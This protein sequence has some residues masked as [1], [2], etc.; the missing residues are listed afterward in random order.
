MRVGGCGVRRRFERGGVEGRCGNRGRGGGDRRRDLDRFVIDDAHD[1]TRDAHVVLEE[2]DRG[3]LAD[4]AREQRLGRDLARPGNVHADVERQCDRGGSG[5]EGR[6][7][8]GRQRRV[9]GRRFHCGGETLADNERHLADDTVGER[10]HDRAG[11]AFGQDLVGGVAELGRAGRQHD[12]VTEQRF[13]RAR[14]DGRDFA[15]GDLVDQRHPLSRFTST[16]NVANRLPRRP[17]TPS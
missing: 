16:I 6:D 13:E 14:D 2:R 5:L 1:D 15:D 17:D 4:D 9:V 8:G 12:V 3:E 11:R 7:G 10:Q